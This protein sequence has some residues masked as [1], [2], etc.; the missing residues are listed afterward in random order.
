VTRTGAYKSIHF[1]ILGG[2]LFLIGVA[3]L[4]NRNGHGTLALTAILAVALLLL[5]GRV[6]AYFWSDLLA[7]LYHLNQRNYLASKEHSERFLAQLHDKPWLRKMIWLGTSTYSRDA[8]VLARNNLGAAMMKL[9]EVD[10]A[11][12][13]LSRAIAL[14]PQCPLPYRNMGVLILNLATYAEAM[15]WFEKAT[16]MGLKYDWTDGLVIASQRRNAAF[17]TIG[18]PTHVEPPRT[19]SEPTVTG[20]FMVELLNDDRTPLEFVVSS[21]EQVFGITGAQAIGIAIAVDRDGSA[22]CA[23]FEAEEAAQTKADL[24]LALAR[25]SDFPL[26]CNVIEITS[27]PPR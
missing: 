20:A 9:G 23:T 19:P 17:S 7:G 25:A 11:K 2:G 4:T 6:L 15:P 22:V 27:I 1:S 24:L 14:D 8:E 21:L 13:Q 10:P 5:P 26:S 3:A 18:V 12:E 16:E